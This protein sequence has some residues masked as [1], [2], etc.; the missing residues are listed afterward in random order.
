MDPIKVRKLIRDRRKREV[1]QQLTLHLKEATEAFV[2]TMRKQGVDRVAD[3]QHEEQIRI[4]LAAQKK[5]MNLLLK[6]QPWKD[7]FVPN[8]LGVY[9]EP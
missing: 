9:R 2:D 6:A 8:Y 3:D 1:D 7:G 5:M 4:V